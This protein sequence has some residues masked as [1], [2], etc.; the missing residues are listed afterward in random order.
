MATGTT[1]VVPILYVF[2]EKSKI[3]YLRPPDAPPPS[4]AQAVMSVLRLIIQLL[5]IPN[6]MHIIH[7]VISVVKSRFEVK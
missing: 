4:L 1:R 2:Y 5:Q 3:H 6:V 7:E